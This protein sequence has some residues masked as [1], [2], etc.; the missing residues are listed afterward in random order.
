MFI[1]AFGKSDRGRERPHS[2]HVTTSF[3]L[4]APRV[5]RVPALSEV[6]KAITY[7]INISFI[8]Q[9]LVWGHKV[10]VNHP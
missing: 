1:R 2:P 3:P 5:R 10:Y 8:K 7:I 4:M 6:P 9:A